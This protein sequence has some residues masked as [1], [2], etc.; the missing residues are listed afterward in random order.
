MYLGKIITFKAIEKI[1][2]DLHIFYLRK[3]SKKFFFEVSLVDHCN[4]NCVGC[5]HFSSIADECFLDVDNYKRD[6]E[7]FSE[8]AR[9]YVALIHLCGGEPLL[10]KNITEIIKITR[11]NFD[12]VI[13]KII[14][15][16]ILLP[17]M[18]SD[19]WNVCK[20]N[21]IIISIT[22][23]PININVKKIYELALQYGITIENDQSPY[24]IKFRKDI[25]DDQGRQSPKYSFRKCR[26]MLCHQLYEGKFYM[27]HIPAYIKYLNKRFSRNFE[28][29]PEDYLDIYKIKNIKT[30]LKYIKRPISF[31]RYCNI[32][33]TDRNITWC[34]SKK[35][36]SEWM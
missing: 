27:C 8:L 29:S 33:A 1:Y 10:H 15:N 13:I 7:R 20:E 2:R 25:Y 35:E 30:L 36:I 18:E 19:F 21:N 14:T 5:S 26:K 23:Y 9:K 24:T 32:D 11:S 4:L 31:C 3:I 28:V 16:G 22:S 12:N 34:L 6:C 17:N